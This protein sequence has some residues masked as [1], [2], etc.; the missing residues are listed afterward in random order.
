MTLT[1]ADR[2]WIETEAR[3]AGFDLAGVAPVPASD[4][5]AAVEADRRFSEWVESGRCGEM[6][7]L[8]RRD[9]EGRLLRGDLRR[10]LPWA[11]SVVVCAQ[12]YNTIAP[13]SI[14]PAKNG[15][16]WIARYAW[17]GEGAGVHEG[18]PAASDYH[19]LLLPKLKRVEEQVRQR[20]GPAVEL[21]SYVDTGP[22]VERGYGGN[23]L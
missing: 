19:T 8:M 18:V 21:R 11:R 5:N 6:E 9:A 1:R 3:S 2:E 4:S 10:A 12:N 22:V 15:A 16:G 17:S 23:R 13:R 7:W 14:D 20:F